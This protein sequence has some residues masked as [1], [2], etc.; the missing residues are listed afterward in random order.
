MQARFATETRHEG[1]GRPN[2]RR[3]NT[4]RQADCQS[5]AGYQPVGMAL[6]ATKGDKNPPGLGVVD[7]TRKGWPG[8]QQRTRGSAL[9]RQVF[10]RAHI[11]SSHSL[12]AVQNRRDTRRNKGIVGQVLKTSNVCPPGKRAG[13]WLAAKSG[14][15]ERTR[16]RCRYWTRRRQAHRSTAYS[17]D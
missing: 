14:R 9:P 6:R 16:P 12:A 3:R 1:R 17:S 4:S 5:A 11:A 2:A 15:T 13:S 10:D 8:G 7:E